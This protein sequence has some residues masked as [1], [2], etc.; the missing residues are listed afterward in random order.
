[1]AESRM[2]IAIYQEGS[3]YQVRVTG[4]SG[5]DVRRL[6]EKLNLANANALRQY[7]VQ[8]FKSLKDV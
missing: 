5:K 3:N 7:A 8:W 6:K 2:R 1:M 4:F